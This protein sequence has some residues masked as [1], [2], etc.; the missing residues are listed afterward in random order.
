M[1]EVLLAL[2][3]ARGSLSE[4][5][6]SWRIVGRYSKLGPKN[7]AKH[8]SALRIAGQTGEGFLFSKSRNEKTLGSL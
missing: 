5:P 2:A 3:D 8:V 6:T 7:R 1:F 4:A